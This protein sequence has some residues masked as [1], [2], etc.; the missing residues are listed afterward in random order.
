ML[1]YMYTGYRLNGYRV[2]CLI[3][4]LLE[5]VTNINPKPS[6]TST[7]WFR[8]K[9]SWITISLQGLYMHRLPQAYLCYDLLLD[10]EPNPTQN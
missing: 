2:I 5:K 8:I 10:S 1:H 9:I 3:G 7:A 4:Y 6:H